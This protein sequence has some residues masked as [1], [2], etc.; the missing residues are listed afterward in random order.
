MTTFLDGGRRACKIGFSNRPTYGL[1]PAARST[2]ISGVSMVRRCWPPQAQLGLPRTLLLPPGRAERRCRHGKRSTTK[3]WYRT[4]RPQLGQVP[5]S[6]GS[7]QASAVSVA[8]GAASGPRPLVLPMASMTSSTSAG[9]LCRRA[10][11]EHWDVTSWSKPSAGRW[12]YRRTGVTQGGSK[13]RF[14]SDNWC[15][16]PS[17]DRHTKRPSGR[18]R[19]KWR[20][21]VA[22]VS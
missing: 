22:P 18:M 15:D 7:A 17:A 5:R 10:H 20:T 12:R 6:F 1:I 19:P 2:G 9:T 4:G 13:A 11:H 21:G 16:C 3:G 8:H 14:R